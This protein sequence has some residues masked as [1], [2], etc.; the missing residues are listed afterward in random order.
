MRH[1]P[2]RALLHGVAATLMAIGLTANAASAA[3]ADLHGAMP[4][5]AQEKRLD[6]LKIGD[7]TKPPAR[8]DPTVWASI[9]PADNVVTPERVALG[10]RLYFDTRLSADGTLAC[11]TCHDVSRGFTDQRPVSEG[12]RDQLGR[13]NAP[14]TMNALLLQTQFLDGRA[15]NL[16]E[17]A[18]LPIVNP[19]EM[20]Q[21]DGIAAATAIGG[22]AEYQKMFQSAYGRSPNYEDIGRA[23]AAFER[24]LVFLDAPF[25]DFVA[26]KPNAISR[27]AQQGW[28]LFN[29]KARCVTCHALNPSN[30]IG[31]DNRFH[32][33]GVAARHRDFE[34]LAGQ[35]LTTLGS[36]G[37][38]DA[39][40]K[41]A[42]STDLSELGRFLVSKQR[43]DI[44]AF[45]TSQLRNIAL[46]APY[47]HDGSMQTLWDVMDH[48][49]KGGEANSYLDGGIEPLAL[50]E[51]EIDQLV[52]FM[53][54]LTDRRF[55]AEN[56]AAFA[57][58]QKRSR[59]TRPFRDNALAQRQVLP[60]AQRVTGDSGK[61]K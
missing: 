58:Q 55:Q 13:R 56:Q 23:I 12:I 48:Y 10:R 21:P 14:T 41:L 20:G 40:D 57:A 61:E 6:A 43:S 54:T 29:G 44:G 17:Q 7:G 33:I 2:E 51:A 42:L 34:T 15:A 50:S 8:I 27:A 25:D 9:V 31:S 19:I 30:P 4:V 37:G 16:E 53:F 59:T 39:V 11:A 3:P 22:D 60:F 5:A 1:I 52:A 38:A 45:K 28:A 49:N 18:K 47:M 46:T 24:T 36:D 32:N 26:G 35:A